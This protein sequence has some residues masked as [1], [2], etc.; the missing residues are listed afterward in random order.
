[1]VMPKI[2][3]KPPAAQAAKAIGTNRQYVAD[4]KAIKAAAPE[5]I[6]QIKAST[7]TVPHPRDD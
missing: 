5:L 7:L 6:P 2:T 1:M 3:H 4:V